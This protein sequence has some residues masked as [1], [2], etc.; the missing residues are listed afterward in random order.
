MIPVRREFPKGVLQ[1]IEIIDDEKVLIQE[2]TTSLKNRER[3]N[4][5]REELLIL[6]PKRNIFIS[7]NNAVH[8]PGK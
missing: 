5:L 4:N 1:L 7:E 8:R 3:M 6:N 2:M